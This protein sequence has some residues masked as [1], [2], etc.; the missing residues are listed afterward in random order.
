VVIGTLKRLTSIGSKI[1]VKWKFKTAPARS[2]TKTKWWFIVHGDKA[3]LQQ[4]QQEW[5]PV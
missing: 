2:N 5:E 4:L 1:T 3:E